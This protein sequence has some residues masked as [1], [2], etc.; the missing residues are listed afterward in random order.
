MRVTP[1]ER[2]EFLKR[3]IAREVADVNL[4]V[5]AEFHALEVEEL[6]AIMNFSPEAMFK[7]LD[8]LFH[9]TSFEQL[10]V[11]KFSSLR[12]PVENLGWRIQGKI[13]VRSKRDNML[14]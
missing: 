7:S 6:G 13:I 1:D 14:A 8:G 9:V 10:K 3:H 4:H 11:S 12:R 5:A 2:S